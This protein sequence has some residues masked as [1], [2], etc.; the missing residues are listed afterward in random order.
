MASVT[1]DGQQYAYDP[2][3]RV[4]LPYD[5][6]TSASDEHGSTNN[7]PVDVRADHGSKPKPKPKDK[8]SPAETTTTV[9]KTATRDGKAV[10]SLTGHVY[11]GISEWPPCE[12][13]TQSAGGSLQVPGAEAVR[14]LACALHGAHAVQA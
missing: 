14:W 9:T 6:A 4:T 12:T 1:V 10:C 7:Y 8:N 13:A 5:V 2:E 3:E 11:S